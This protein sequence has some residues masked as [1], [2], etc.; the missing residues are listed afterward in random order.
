MRILCVNAGSSSL[1]FALFDDSLARLVEGTE[2]STDHLGAMEAA[3]DAVAARGTPDAVAHRL[4]H[5]GPEL[6]RPQRLTPEIL[7][8][9]RKIVHFAPIHLPPALDCIEAAARRHPGVPQVA[10]FDTSFHWNLPAVS[11]RLPL[12]RNLDEEGVRRYG[13]HGLSYEYVVSALGPRL[14]Q[15]AVIAHLGNGASLVAIRDGLSIDTTMGLTPSGGIPMSTRSGDLDPG[16][17]AFL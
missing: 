14:G 15:R 6:H 5:G 16:I 10:C 17:V 12:P 3:L 9:L 4:V 13:F 1:K 11:R 7:A 2:E 8:E